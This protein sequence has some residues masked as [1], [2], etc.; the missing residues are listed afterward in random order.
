MSFISLGGHSC[1]HITHSDVPQLLIVVEVLLDGGDTA[2]LADP[3][4]V[5]EGTEPALDE[6]FLTDVE[7]RPQVVGL[8]FLTLREKDFP[9]GLVIDE[10]LL[11]LFDVLADT[12]DLGGDFLLLLLGDG[13]VLHRVHRVDD[14]RDLLDG[15]GDDGTEGFEVVVDVADGHIH[16]FVGGYDQ[17]VTADEAEQSD[18]KL[19]GVETVVAVG[20]DDAR[21]RVNV[22]GSVLVLLD[23]FHIRVLERNHVETADARRVLL[24]T[25]L[26]GLNG[27]PA[28]FGEVVD[29]GLRV[30]IHVAVGNSRIRRSGLERHRANFAEF[31]VGQE[32]GRE[33]VVSERKHCV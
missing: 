1:G 23:D 28:E 26:L 19:E 9:D 4:V 15:G 17:S 24:A 29:D 13:H 11:V 7:D 10:E 2:L 30:R 6:L 5:A 8:V 12:H 25:A 14:V 16:H 20:E 31:I 32:I 3:V 27:K 22:L 33:L 18:H 21:E